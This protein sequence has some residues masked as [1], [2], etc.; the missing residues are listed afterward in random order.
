MEPA[1]PF[2]VYSPQSIM[3]RRPPSRALATPRTTLLLVVCLALAA[4]TSACKTK[5][6]HD[7]EAKGDI[8]FL[9]ADLSP[10][11][12]QA[13]GRLGDNNPRA[14]AQVETRAKQGDVNAYLAAWQAHV[15]GASWS[16]ALLRGALSDPTRAVVAQAALPRKDPRSADFVPEIEASFGAV[17]GPD[18]RKLGALLSSL[19]AASKAPVARSLAKPKTRAAI[20]EALS[21]PDTSAEALAAFRDAKPEERDD[22][23]CTALAAARAQ[24]DDE[25]LGWLATKA[26]PGLLTA[27]SRRGTL[28]CNR[29]AKLWQQAL[30]S[31]LP[32]AHPALSQ[33][34]VASTRRCTST[35]DP[36]LAKALTDAEESRAW[37]VTAFDPQDALFARLDKTCEAMKVTALGGLGISVRVR[38]RARDAVARGCSVGKKP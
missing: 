9:E 32:D 18:S 3:T 6:V 16:T 37:V 10:E 33:E 35:H 21:S 2:L 29:A 31:R 20:C 34:L 27:A 26:E 5:D 4:T 24:T 28:D 19:G 11:S 12:T 17:Q 36:V 1:S 30:G 8:A 7:A 22:A 25:T 13:L 23:A 38:E 15:R 14:L